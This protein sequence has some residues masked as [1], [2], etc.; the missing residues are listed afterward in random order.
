[1]RRRYHAV[2]LAAICVGASDMALAQE[3]AADSACTYD[4]CGVWLER[5]RLRQGISGRVVAQA[6]FFRPLRLA[7]LMTG[8]DS[9]AL[10]ARRFDG[11]SA[12]AN[13]WNVGGLAAMATGIGMYY[14]RTRRGHLANDDATVGEGALAFGG[15]AAIYISVVV[16]YTAAPMRDRAVWW[17]NRRFGAAPAR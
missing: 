16:G 2:F 6:G 5:N 3:G 12:A 17:Y 8:T 1:M 7:P 9:A 15:V 13:R 10:L 11:R 14:A 4:R